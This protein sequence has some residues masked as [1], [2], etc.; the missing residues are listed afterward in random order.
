MV[1]PRADLGA[2]EFKRV[3][4]EMFARD[5][6]LGGCGVVIVVVRRCIVGVLDS[7]VVSDDLARFAEPDHGEGSVDLIGVAI[8]VVPSDTRINTFV[9]DDDR[10]VSLG[11]VVPGIVGMDENLFGGVGENVTGGIDKRDVDR[12]RIDRAG[13]IFGTVDQVRRGQNVE[14]GRKEF[15]CAVFGGFAAVG[16]SAFR[17]VFAGSFGNGSDCRGTD[18]DIRNACI[19]ADRVADM[20]LD[21]VKRG[22]RRVDVVTGRRSGGRDQRAGQAVVRDKLARVD[23]RF[24]RVVLVLPPAG[25]G[26]DERPLGIHSDGGEPLVAK[27]CFIDRELFPFHS[28]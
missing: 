15:P 24:D 10:Q 7:L 14:S 21:A 12:T 5:R 27:G 3:S 17:T 1:V 25:P 19:C 26:D 11:Q 23:V 4:P 6:F 16:T 13:G 22:D 20:V 9:K 8:N 2:V 28:V 18:P